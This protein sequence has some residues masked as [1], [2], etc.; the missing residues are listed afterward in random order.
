MHMHRRTPEM[1]TREIYRISEE[2]YRAEQSQRKLEHLEEAFDEHI[3][4]KDRLF[5]ELQQTFLTGEMAYETENRVGWLKREQHLIMDKI[6][7]ER[8]QLRQKRYL[9]DEQ[10]ESLYRV[11]RNAWKETE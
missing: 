8:E 6:T 11:R 4:Q 3:Y 1:I 5:G 10:E 9:L 7:T 2:K